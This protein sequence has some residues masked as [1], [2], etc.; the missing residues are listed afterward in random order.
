MTTFF[1]VI[2]FFTVGSILL[3]ITID[4][5]ETILATWDKN[6]LN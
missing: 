4:L 2:G 6:D 3:V 5:L 1:A